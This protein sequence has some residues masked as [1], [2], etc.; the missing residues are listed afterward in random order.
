VFR[1]AYISKEDQAKIVKSIESAEL[2][3]SGEIRV[4][5]ENKCKNDPIP[6]A[7]LVFNKLKMFKT[8]ERNGVLIYLALN[9]KKFAIIGDVGINAKVPENFWEDVKETIFTHF[10]S[11]NLTEGLC[12]AIELSGSKLKEFFPRKDD[13]INEQSDEISF[14]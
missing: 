11:G 7:V 4:H 2:N 9:S 1:K 12:I 13:D 10:R 14:G 8:A 5:I 6:R 3:T